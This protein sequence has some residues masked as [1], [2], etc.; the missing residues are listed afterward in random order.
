M[1]TG[2]HLER[3]ETLALMN[4]KEKKEYMDLVPAK[5]GGLNNT[6]NSE[7]FMKACKL[8][9]GVSNRKMI[10]LTLKHAHNG[11]VMLVG[12]TLLHQKVLKDMLVEK[13][14]DEKDIYVLDQ[15]SIYLTDESVESKQYPDYKVVIV[16]IRK[17]TGYTLS[18]L[19]HMVT[20]IYPSNEANRTQ[21]LGR[22]NRIGQSAKQIDIYFV[23]CGIFSYIMMNHAMAGSIVKCMQEI[24]NK[25]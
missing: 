25:K 15:E 8:C 2:I 22:L 10:E 17:S 12:Q 5:F 9:Y 24:I 13:G 19:K 1:S 3:I 16:S 14:M 21:L 6:F 20:G 23:H 7:L 11:G 18:R 4:S